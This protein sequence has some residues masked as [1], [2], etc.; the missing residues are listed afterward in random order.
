MSKEK[1]D[2]KK[3]YYLF[4]MDINKVNI[5][6]ITLFVVFIIISALIYPNNLGKEF[7]EVNLVLLVA[8]YVIWLLLHELLHSLAYTIYGASFKKI[9]YGAYLEKGI[10]YCLCKQNITRKNI[11]NSLMFPLFYIGIITY[12]IAIIFRL[13][14]LLFLSISNIA[15]SAGD[16]IMFTYI[17]KLNKNIEFSEYDNPTQFAIYSDEDVSKIKHYGLNYIESTDTLKRTNLKKVIISKGSIIAIL[18]LVIF[19]VLS[20]VL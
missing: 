12:V 6:C 5:L 10:L 9:I 1:S 20:I 18:V 15:G 11:L 16:I 17:S 13:P 2:T 4:E 7:Y 3:K 14:M 8:L 19:T